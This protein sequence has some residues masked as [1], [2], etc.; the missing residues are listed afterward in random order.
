MAEEPRQLLTIDKRL[1]LTEKRAV[2][3]PVPLRLLAS[4]F[5]VALLGWLAAA[6]VLVVAAPDLAAG[7]T[8]ARAPVLAA[9]LLALVFLPLAVSGG[10]FHLLPVMLRNDLRSPRRLWLALPLL[11]AG[12]GL[13]APGVAFD[14]PRLLWPG[15]TLVTAGLALVLVELGGLVVRAPRGRMLVASRTGVALSLFHVVAA[16][17]LGSLLFSNGDRTVLGVTHDRW[18]LVHLHVAL[19]G[20]VAMLILTVGRT[21][22]PMLAVAPTAPGRRAPVD[23]IA[24]A[25]GVWL[26]ATGIA[27]S[28]WLAVV[29]AVVVLLALARFGA[30]VLRVARTRR[31]ELEGPLAHLLAGA[32]FLLQAAALGFA[33]LAG[34]AHEERRTGA[35]VL[36][37]L[38]G[39]AAGVT[40]GHLP[41]LLSLSLW[42][43]WPPGPRPKQDAL[44]PRRLAQAEAVAFAAGVET[45]ALGAF[46]G[47]VAAARAGGAL[48]VVAAALAVAAATGVWTRRRREMSSVTLDE[49]LG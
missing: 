17:V 45:L 5:G 32:A 10:A 41:K 25:A 8:G 48:L 38:L 33:L 42:V 31:I 40:L 24:L 43:W 7:D 12:G 4:Y 30:L 15:A 39:W 26:L 23:E 19:L 37:L 20:W 22:A 16:L 14:V 47:N 29:G 13:T 34:I 35:Y 49:R 28:R 2:G 44:Y 21:L 1:S 6:V 46:L 27:I 11:A 18:L 9:H 36:L 3:G